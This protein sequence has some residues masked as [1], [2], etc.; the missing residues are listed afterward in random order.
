MISKS[1][2]C[3]SSLEI[4]PGIVI[5]GYVITVKVLFVYM[6]QSEILEINVQ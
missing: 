1:E 2:G 6:C 5:T 4:T 3:S